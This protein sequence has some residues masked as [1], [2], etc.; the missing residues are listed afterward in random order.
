MNGGSPGKVLSSVY[1]EYPWFPWKLPLSK[2]V[3]WSNP[4]SWKPLLDYIGTKLNVKEPSDWYKVK[5]EVNKIYKILSLS[6]H[7]N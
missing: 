2:T 1:P 7:S 4:K 3:Y 6:F 5:P